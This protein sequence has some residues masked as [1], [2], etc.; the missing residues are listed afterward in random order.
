MTINELGMNTVYMM[1]SGQHGTLHIGVTSELFIRVGQHREGLV[2]G[3][4]KRHGVKRLV[5]F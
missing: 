5:W 1:A 3:F 4:T 2:D